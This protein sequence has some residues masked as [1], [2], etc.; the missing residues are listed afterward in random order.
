M[1][2]YLQEVIDLHV[3]IEA[4]FAK[5]DAQVEAMLERFHPD[6]SMITPTGVQVSLQEVATLFTQR[7][8][9]QPGLIVEVT[10]METLAQWQE[11]AVIRYRETHYLPAQDAKTRISTALL[12]HQGERV[13]WRHLHETWAANPA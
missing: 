4:L 11:G 5:G 13:L 3:M 8:G 6:F 7:S 10:E 12:S 9:S 1:N 2:P